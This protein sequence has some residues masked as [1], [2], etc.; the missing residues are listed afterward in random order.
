M[1]RIA[2]IAL[3]ATLPACVSAPGIAQVGPTQA[4]QII[5]QQ[6]S[7]I[8][9]D[10]DSVRDAQIGSVMPGPFGSTLVCVRLNARNGF[11]GYTGLTESVIQIGANRQVVNVQKAI[12]SSGCN[13]YLYRPFPELS[14]S[15]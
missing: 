12:W 7:M 15:Q 9:K 2:A 10:P 11:G 1:K 6:R 5:V 8:F 13:Q 3:L 14:R 4:R